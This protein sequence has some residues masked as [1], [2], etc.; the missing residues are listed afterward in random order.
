MAKGQESGGKVLRIGVL[1]ASITIAVFA[2]CFFLVNT[3]GVSAPPE[4]VHMAE[5]N[6]IKFR[7]HLI[8]TEPFGRPYLNQTSANIPA[9]LLDH[10]EIIHNYHAELSSRVQV[11][12]THSATVTVTARQNRGAL[13]DDSNPII[14]NRT[15][16]LCHNNKN[17]TSLEAC[18]IFENTAPNRIQGESYSYQES[19]LL[20]LQPYIDFVKTTTASFVDYPIRA[21]I[22]INFQTFASNNGQLRSNFRRSMTVPLTEEN[23][24]IGITG[25][26]SRGA[27]YYAPER[28]LQGTIMLAVSAALAVIG[29][30]VA[31]VM[32]KRLPNRKDQSR[33]E[34]DRYLRDYNDAI[35]VT[36]TA[37]NVRAYKEHITIGS[38]KELLKL[39]TATGNPI[40]YFESRSG[41]F[42]YCSKEEIIYCFIIWKGKRGAG[43]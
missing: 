30:G 42:F 33:Q 29:A 23:F 21:S 39:A 32:V 6:Q 2:G 1:I 38:F 26:E 15:F 37:P 18:A 13:N 17:A 19:Y 10:I 9:S 3:I 25:E 36:N 35:I 34:V 8:D 20:Y 22:T 31:V 5:S 16:P 4:F 11:F 41:A 24:T 27:D 43:G 14:L 12:F 28:T 7:A 40:I